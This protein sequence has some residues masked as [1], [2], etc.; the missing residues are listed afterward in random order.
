MYARETH[1]H[2]A[3]LRSSKDAAAVKRSEADAAPLADRC[4]P[5]SLPAFT[6][7]AVCVPVVGQFCID[8]VLLH[9]VDAR[10]GFCM[11]Q[12]QA[13]T[14]CELFGLGYITP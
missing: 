2:T 11:N 10:V 3:L 4:L 1:T 14:H 6:S 13:T 7:Y 8:A 5:T 9:A 12:A